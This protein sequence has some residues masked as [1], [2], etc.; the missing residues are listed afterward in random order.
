M[1]NTLAQNSIIEIDGGRINVLKP[2][3]PK[4]EI[5]VRYQ[6]AKAP[7]VQGNV[8]LPTS[9]DFCRQLIDL[10]RL[11]TRSEINLISSQVGRDV[12]TE[13]GGWYT[14]KGTDTATPYCRHIW[15]QVIAIKR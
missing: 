8:I 3:T 9:R 7:R 1:I 10:D 11:Y 13:R 2:E 15:Q 12:W 4:A 14:K 5:V 6:Y